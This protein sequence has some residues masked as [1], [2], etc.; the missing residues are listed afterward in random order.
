MGMNKQQR[1]QT[2]NMKK[3]EKKADELV[4]LVLVCCEERLCKVCGHPD[5]HAASLT[6]AALTVRDAIKTFMSLDRVP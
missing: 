3:L 6:F 5:Y 1:G 4:N 2:P